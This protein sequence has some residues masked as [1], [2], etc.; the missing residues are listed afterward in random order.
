VLVSGADGDDPIGA[1]HLE[2][3]VSVVWDSHELCVAWPS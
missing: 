1:W 2:L 3:E